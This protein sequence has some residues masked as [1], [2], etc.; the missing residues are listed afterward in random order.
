MGHRAITQVM[1]RVSDSKSDADFN[2]FFSL[3]LAG[4]ALFKTITLGMLAALEDDK[5]RNRY[6]LEHT[7][8]RADGLGEW[9]RAL[10]DALS[11]PAS[12]F[13][14][15]EAQSDQAELARLSA[16]GTWQH[17]AVASLKSALSL[18]NIE[19]ED[20]PAR[21][22][23]KRWFRLFVTL[24]NKTRGHGA[25]SP[26]KATLAISDLEKSIEAISANL[27]GVPNFV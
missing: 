19:A 21:T 6:R 25:T 1:Q 13:L 27:E 16:T 11:G 10:E 14:L 23:L 20:V 26:S 18:L 17:Q 7:L 22:D 4:E 9:G 24:R 15:T 8:A 3:L 2:Y 5:D 12:Q